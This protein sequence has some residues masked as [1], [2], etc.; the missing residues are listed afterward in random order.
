MQH[1]VSQCVACVNR[2]LYD[3]LIM[4]RDLTAFGIEVQEHLDRLGWSRRRLAEEAGLTAGTVSRVMR[5][6]NRP[7]DETIEAIAGALRID[8]LHLKR[9]AGYIAPKPSDRH[10]SVEYIANRLN[11]LPPVVREEAIQALGAQLDT[12]YRI[13]GISSTDP[14]KTASQESSASVQAMITELV[15]LAQEKPETLQQIVEQLQALRESEAKG[16]P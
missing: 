9:L 15:R 6:L 3:Y 4:A 12:I 2:V 1:I 16:E 10:A 13:A 14:H 5:G 7:E 8:S 11:A